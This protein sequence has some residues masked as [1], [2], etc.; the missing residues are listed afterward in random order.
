MF[1]KPLAIAG[2]SSSPLQRPALLEFPL[3]QEDAVRAKAAPSHQVGTMTHF[4]Y[5]VH[6]E[7]TDMT[8]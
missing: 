5:F 2:H 3:R 6:F 4:V 7:M 1:L 8:L